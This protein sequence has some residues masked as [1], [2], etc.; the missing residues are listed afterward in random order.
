MFISNFNKEQIEIYS[1]YISC[2]AS[3]SGLFSDSKIPFLHYRT[4]ENIFCKSFQAEDLARADIAYDAKL[5]SVGVG[6]KT[7]ISSNKASREKIAEFN[8]YSQELGKLDKENLVKRLA[9]LRNER[10]E[11]ADRTYRIKKGIYHCLTRQE[12]T[13]NIFETDYS[14]ININRIKNIKKT[15]PS[16]FFE[17]DQNEYSY[18][19]SKSTLYC[20][21][22]TPANSLTIPIHII[23]DPYELILKIFDHY[24]IEK[25]KELENVILPLYSTRS[26]KEKIVPK[27][28]GLNQWNASG[29]ERDFGEVYIPI[30]SKIHHSYPTFFPHRDQTFKLILPNQDELLCKVCQEGGKAL[31]SN[32]NKALSKWLLRE[33]FKLVEG[34]ILTYERLKKLGVDSVKITK[35]NKKTFRIDFVQINSYEKFLKFTKEKN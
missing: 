5:D 12:N 34:E 21:F 23:K 8:I 3:L 32:P 20:K 2:I 24:R 11:F 1:K 6:L 27:K 9:D 31:M 26:P 4:V 7:F 33:V 22:Y 30:P 28:S 29:R 25:Q 18:N 13:I 35:I 14:P 10:I 17:D 16:L 19:F 15:K